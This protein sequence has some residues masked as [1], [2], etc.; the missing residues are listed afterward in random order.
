M[1]MLSERKVRL[2]PEQ[3]LQNNQFRKREEKK[4]R[5]NYAH[6]PETIQEKKQS[7]NEEPKKK[8]VTT[9]QVN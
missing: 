3:Q 2:E 6:K 7:T 5:E 9:T 4:T 1:R 8:F